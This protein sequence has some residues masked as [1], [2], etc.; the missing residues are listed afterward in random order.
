LIDINTSFKNKYFHQKKDSFK[1]VKQDMLRT[2]LLWQFYHHNLTGKWKRLFS[3]DIIKIIGNDAFR[4]KQFYR[5][6]FRDS[7]VEKVYAYYN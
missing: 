6:F 7:F 4:S 3:Y 1:Q 2:M 5:Q